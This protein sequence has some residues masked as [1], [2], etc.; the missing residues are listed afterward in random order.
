MKIKKID[1]S[2]LKISIKIYFVGLR[3]RLI[4]IGIVLLIDACSLITF[5]K[6]QNNY[7]YVDFD[8]NTG[9]A[10]YC[11]QQQSALICTRSNGARI[12]VKQY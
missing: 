8:N 5:N 12:I 6:N 4:I 10:K 9:I 2:N 3:L 7:F 1:L 11:E